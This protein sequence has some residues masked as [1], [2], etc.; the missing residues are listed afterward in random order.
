MLSSTSLPLTN[1]VF[2]HA[3]TISNTSESFKTSHKAPIPRTVIHNSSNTSSQSRA[4]QVS[5]PLAASLSMLLWSSPVNAGILSGSK[6]LESIPGPELPRID[7]LN[8]FNDENQKRY[9]EFDEKFKQSPLLKKLLEQSEKNKEKNKQEIQ[10]KY[11]LRGAEWGVGDCSTAGMTETQRD[12]FI[13][14]LK[15]KV[16][17]INM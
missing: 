11:C 1:S 2:N 4:L 8:K 17:D 16:D 12:E 3:T 14:M 10:D 15:K 7:F 6:G 5:L 9:A 13:T